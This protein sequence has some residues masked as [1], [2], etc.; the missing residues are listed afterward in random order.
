M[1][2]GR[3]SV[4]GEKAGVDIDASQ[5]R[6]VEKRLRQNLA[7][8]YDDI[9]IGMKRAERFQKVG[10][11]CFH[12][13]KNRNVGRKMDRRLLHRRWSDSKRAPF[14]TVRLSDDCRNI[15]ALLQ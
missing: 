7:E 3:A 2:G 13:L 1:D 6:D 10:I 15:D 11:G 12:G 8:R 9:E 4:F 5:W 14:G